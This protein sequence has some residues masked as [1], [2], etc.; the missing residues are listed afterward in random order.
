MDKIGATDPP[1]TIPFMKLTGD[2]VVIIV[3]APPIIFPFTVNDCAVDPTFMAFDTSPDVTLPV[4]IKN[5]A[6]EL[7]VAF[8]VPV[9]PVGPFIFPI[10]VVVPG[11][12]LLIVTTPFTELTPLK[13]IPDTVKLQ[14]PEWLISISLVV[15]LG[16][17]FPPKL[18][19][20]VPLF[21]VTCIKL[22]APGLKGLIFVT[23]PD[24]LPLL[25][26]NDPPALIPVPDV[27]L[28]DN[29]SKLVSIFTLKLFENTSSEAVGIKL[30][31]HIAALLQLPDDIGHLFGIIKILRY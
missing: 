6:P 16:V 26:T 28:N 10:T 21:A 23:L 24:I 29:T 2:A 11:E 31:L 18:N 30:P 19:P 14:L 13:F 9:P 4:T 8:G 20:T 22:V 1:V 15:A 7:I 12:D 5:P 25:N 3:A 17:T 27:L